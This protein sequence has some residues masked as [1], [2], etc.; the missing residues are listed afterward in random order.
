MLVW[1]FILWFL[2]MLFRFSLNIEIWSKANDLW[3]SKQTIPTKADDLVR[4]KTFFGL[5]QTIFWA[6]ADGLWFKAHD[7][8]SWKQTT[9][10]A[11][12]DD[13]TWNILREI[14]YVCFHLQDRPLWLKS[15]LSPR[16]VCFR[17]DRPLL[18]GPLEFI[19]W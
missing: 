1:W 16:V 11:K 9:L 6:E 10:W 12:A 13:P 17:R 15:L 14:S 19:Q 18:T 2:K 8:E 4:K 3:V 5:K 7:L